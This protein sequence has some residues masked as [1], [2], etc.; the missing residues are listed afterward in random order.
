MIFKTCTSSTALR[1]SGAL[2]LIL[3]TDC[4]PHATDNERVVRQTVTEFGQ[5]LKQVPLSADR[6]TAIPAMEQHYG[7]LVS[8]S[9]LDAWSANPPAAPGRLTSSPWPDRIEIDTVL[10]VSANE[11]RVTGRV[12]E[13]TSVE[14]SQ[15]APGMAMPVKLTL[16]N[17]NGK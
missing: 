10:A 13:M 4:S 16:E 1:L 5:A 3:L 9:L 7:K 15:H 12:M 17:Q 14:V 6:E 11:F 8:P 2:L